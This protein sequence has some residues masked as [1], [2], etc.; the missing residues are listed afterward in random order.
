[1]GERG[2]R[3]R[4]DVSRLPKTCAAHAVLVA[5]LL[6]WISPAWGQVG[7]TTSNANLLYSCD[8]NPDCSNLHKVMDDTQLPQNV[9]RLKVVGAPSDRPVRYIW[10]MKKSAKGILAADLDIT[11]GGATPAIEAM[12][13]EFGNACILTK[14]KLNFYNEGTIFFVAPTCDVLPTD[15]RKA[16]HGGVSRVQVKVLDGKRKIGRGS[17]DVAWGQNGSVTLFVSDMEDPPRFQNGMPRSYPVSVFANPTFAWDATAPTPLPPGTVTAEFSGGGT[18][19]GVGTCAPFDGCEEID[20]PAGGRFLVQLKLEFPQPS[21]AAICDNIT[22]N[23]ATCNPGGRLEVIPSPRRRKYDPQNPGQANVDLRVRLTNTSVPKGGLPAC[24]FLL[25]GANVLSCT[26]QLKV[27]SVTDTKGMTFDLKHCSATTTHACDR[28]A[29][30]DPAVCDDCQAAE[31][32]LTKPHCSKHFTNE[33]G[34]ETDCDK[35]SATCPDC[36]EGETCVRILE[37]GTGKDLYMRPGESAD[38]FHQPIT[39]SNVLGSTA[40][41]ADTWTAN[42][43]IPPINFDGT[44]KYSIVGRPN[45]APPP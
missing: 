17:A 13:G 4:G 29:D 2:R 27:G 35:G 26:S 21:C 6:A 12:C 24:P 1:M 39:L 10:S 36:D 11:P 34:K 9:A 19:G 44:L 40:H 20:F 18:V 8:A 22:V 37:V 5:A 32:C 14:D 45:L 7:L 31:V 33:C 16:F 41:I 38:L 3:W 30:C 15:T 43:F 28:D 23:V 42:V 25:R